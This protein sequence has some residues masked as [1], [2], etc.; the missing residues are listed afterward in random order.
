MKLRNIVKSLFLI[1]SIVS[2]G[3]SQNLLNIGIGPTWPKG[4]RDSD[5]KTAWNATVEYGR[6]FDNIIGF[7]LDLDF[8]SPRGGV[9]PREKGGISPREKGVVPPRERG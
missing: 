5:K 2:F 7:G 9:S 4:L 6:L 1:T 8:S 3:F